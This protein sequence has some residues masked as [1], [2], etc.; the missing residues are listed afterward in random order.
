[1]SLLNNL[2]AVEAY[3]QELVTEGQIVSKR[4]LFSM[5]YPKKLIEVA[6]PLDDINA[7][8]I[9]E[10]SIRHGHPSTLHLWWARRPLAAA[11]AVLFAQLVNDPG[12]EPG[13]GAYVGQ[14]KAD[15]QQERERLFEIIRALVKWENTTNE[16]VLAKA[17]AEIIKSWQETCAITGDDPENMPPFLDPFSGGGT[18]P[19]EA[20]RLGLKANGSDLNPVA[21]LIGKALIEIPPKFAGRAPVGPPL[22][23]SIAQ[24]SW[25]GA[26]GL[27]EDI[28]RYGTWMRAEA[29]KRIGHFY[30]LVDLPKEHGG[31]KATVI[32]WLWARTVAS[33]NPAYS[34]VHVPLVH[35]FWLSTKKG[36][37]VW[38]EPL[39]T[40]DGMNYQFEVRYGGCP[41]IEG[42]MNR[43]GGVCLLSE[44]PI[45]FA[46]IR[47]E[48]KAGRM[49]TRL[50]VIVAEGTKGRIYFNPTIEMNEIAN[51]AKPCNTPQT[52]LPKKALGFRVQEYGILT[53]CDLFTSRQLLALT[54]F[55]DLILEARIKAI[56]DAKNL[57]WIDDGKGLAESGNGATAYGDALAVYLGLVED[58]I[59]DRGSTICS[60]D[61][62]CEKIRNTFARQAIPMVWDFAEAN[63]FSS[64]TGNWLAGID[65]ICKSIITTPASKIGGEIQMDATQLN[66]SE[67]AII[68]TDPPYFDNIGYADLSDFFYV[69]LRRALKFILPDLFTTL[70]TPKKEELIASPYRHDGKKPAEAFFMAGMGKALQRIVD[71]THPAFPVTIYYAFKQSETDKDG[72]ISTGWETFLEAVIRTGFII[73]GTWPLR[74]ELS[75]RMLSIGTNALASSIVLVCRQRPKN[76]DIISRRQFQRE[77][78]NTLPDALETM[79]GGEKGVSPIVPV[80]LSQ[81]AIGTGIA[82]YSQYAQ[83]LE[84]DGTSMSIRTAL[85][86]I[87]Q[88]IDEY[89]TQAEG[90]MD[91]DTRFC[92]EWFQ[93]YGFNQGDF[94]QADVLARAKGTSVEGIKQTEIID[95]SKGKV[96]LKKYQEYPQDWHPDSDR[97]PIWKACHHLIG[98]LQFQ[99]EMIAGTLLARFPDQA[100]AIRQLAYRLYTLCER[101]NW[102]EEARV[103]NQL[104]TS[105]PAIVVASQIIT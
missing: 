21:V 2:L 57:G 3:Q 17:R 47:E 68:S 102:A 69:W 8:A 19:L 60:W 39:L 36:K 6:L 92:V 79:I 45:P 41:K 14:T 90:D 89:F 16:E 54:T 85:I 88:T 13:W 28:R 44:S 26:M 77:L 12:E 46:Y 80:D 34:S 25:Q 23:G 50:M 51:S 81:A 100:E 99:S 27:A 29:F 103:Y 22:E 18:F 91:T 93:Q 1:M 24:Q 97:L 35:S 58:K 72:T 96:R 105:W 43:Q 78:R 7:A 9:R 48:G 82:I 73:T 94:G 64:S 15:A 49:G 5:K 55:S 70:L 98:T 86:M 76:A 66:L 87:N 33:P 95:A 61:S 65:W 10:K 104:M 20:Q 31:G 30:P 71:N 52:A 11:R 67:K 83:I 62:S 37:A 59:V 63:P 40:E 42:T 32:A 75:N 53:H 101:K 84:A 38:I 56:E 74:T 4:E